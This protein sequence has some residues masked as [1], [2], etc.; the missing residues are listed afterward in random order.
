MGTGQTSTPGQTM[1]SGKTIL[2]NMDE[3]LYTNKINEFVD[4]VSG[5]NVFTGEQVTGGQKVSG[6]SI[7]ELLQDR[8]RNPIVVDEDQTS[9][10][11]R[12]FSSK[13]A[14]DLFYENPS[15][16]AELQLFTVPRPSDYTLS[17]TI[18]NDGDR[19]VKV[20][21]DVTDK[22]VMHFTWKIHNDREDDA[23]DVLNVTYVI[24]NADGTTHTFTRRRNHHQAED[25]SL[26]EFLKPGINDINVEARGNSTGAL[27]SFSFKITVLDLR[28]ECGFNFAGHHAKN[29]ALRVPYSFYRNNTNGTA[30]IYFCIDGVEMPL[31]TVDVLEGGQ[32]TFEDSGKMINPI[33]TEGQHSLQVYAKADYDGL[34]IYSNVL[35]FTFVVDSTEAGAIDKFINVA[36]SLTSGVPPFSTLTLSGVQYYESELKWSYYTYAANTDTKLSV[37]WKLLNGEDDQNPQEFSPIDAQTGYEPDPLA[38][39]PTIYTTTE[40]IY[41]AAYYTAYNGVE[42]EL[43]RIPIYIIQNSALA[44]IYETGSY[45]L[46]MSAYGRTNGSADKAIW[47]DSTDT[48][49]TTFTGIDWNPNNG[50]YDN[51]FRTSGTGHYA[52]VN[53]EPFDNKNGE[54]GFPFTHGKTIEIE[55]ESEKVNSD[56]DILILIGNPQGARIEITPNTATLYANPV[57]DPNTQQRT[58]V[59]VVH[60]NYKSNERIK[61]AFII[62]KEAENVSQRTTDDGLAY[63]VNNGIL[64]RGALASGRSFSTTGAMDLETDPQNPTPIPCK[65]KIGGSNSGVRVYSI[66]VYDK[67]LSYSDAYN[68]FVYDSSD[69]VAI[70]K[71][72]NILSQGEI[73]FDKCR[74][75]IDT[76]VITGDLTD[77]LNQNNDKDTST[78]DV[79][80]ERYCYYDE[81]KDFQIGD[82]IDDPDRPGRQKV[83][84]G[85][86]IRKHGQST[87]NYP[88]A[89][90]KFWMNKSKSGEIPIFEKTGQSKLMLNK[91]R[92]KMKNDSIPSNK[93][94]LQA[95][96]ADSSGVHN[97]GLLRLIQ[98]SWY[99]A[100]IQG[101]SDPYKLRTLPQLFASIKSNEKQNYGLDHVW[102]DYFPGKDFP[103]NIRVAPDSF[104]C[105][106]FYRDLSGSGKYT[107]LGQYVFMDDKK[108]DFVYGERSMYKVQTDPFCLTVTH[109]DEDTKDNRI[110]N[111][112]NVLRIEVLEVNKSYSSYLTDSGFDTFSGGKYGWESQFEMIYPD[113]DDL[114]EDDE[115]DGLSK[116]NSNSHFARAAQPFVD[117]YKWLV[118]TRNNHEKFRAEAEDHLDLYKLAA[119]YI[120]VLRFALVDSLERN[121]QIKTYD[122]VHFHYEPWDMDIALGNKNDGGIAFNPPV[123][124]NTKLNTTTY[125]ISGRAADQNG[126][127][128]SSNWLWDA[129]EAW[130][131][132]MND[133]V[134]K[135]ADALFNTTYLTYDNVSHMF[136]EEYANKWCEIMYNQSGH[137]KYVDSAGGDLQRWLGWLQG[138]RM[139][140]RHWWLSTSMDYYDAKWFCGDYKAHRVYLAANISAD[141]NKSI[142]I[143]PNGSTYMTVTVNYLDDNNNTESEE[144]DTT[145][146]VSKLNPLVYSMEDGASTKAPIHIYGANFMESIDMSD[147]AIGIDALDITGTYS[148]VL[149]APLKVLNIGTPMTENGGVYSTTL[150]P[151]TCGISPVAEGRNAFENLETLNIR[152]HKHLGNVQQF[153]FGINQWI[154]DLNMSQ[155]KNFYAMGSN[156]I[157]FYSSND[158]NNFNEIELPSTVSIINMKNSTWN[159]M[160]FW[161]TTE[162]EN[163]QATITYHQ[164]ALTGGGYAN[165]PSSITEVHFLGS[166]GRTRESLLFVREWIKSIVSTYGEIAL[167]NYTIEMDDV[168]WSPD[169]IGNDADLLTYDELR[170]IAKMNGARTNLRGYVMLQYEGAGTELTSQQLTE[171]RNWFGDSVFTKGSAGLVVDYKHDYIQIN[172]GGDITIENGQMYMAEGGSAILSAT[173]F[174]LA[175]PDQQSMANYEWGLYE[176]GEQELK[177]QIGGVQLLDAS[178]TSDHNYYLVSSESQIGHN[179]DV[180]VRVTAGGNVYS[181]TIHVRAASYPSSISIGT[182]RYGTI[183]PRVSGDIIAIWQNGI[184]CNIFATTNDTYTA[185]IRQVTYEITTENGRT[186]TYSTK[187]GPSWSGERYNIDT[188]I[189]I[190]EN[191]NTLGINN[192]PCIRVN[193]PDGVP[194]DESIYE[195]NL[196]I[197]VEFNSD[198]EVSTTA[199][200]LVL[201]D[202][203]PIVSAL[204]EYMYAAIADRWLVQYG[205]TLQAS[206]L[207][208]TDL[209]N[210]TGTLT[211]STSLQNLVTAKGTTSLLKY[212]P[213]VT[214]L[215]FDGNSNLQSTNNSI[216]DDN[217]NQFIFTNMPNLETLSIQNCTGLTADIDLSS[218]SHITQVD[219]SGTFVNILVPE[220]AILTKYEVGTPTEISLI[221]PTVLT[222]AGVKVDNCS[223]LN[224]LDITNIPNNNSFSMFEKIMKTFIAGG[225]ILTGMSTMDRSPGY[226]Q[227]D[228]ENKYITS[229]IQVNGGDSIHVDVTND[230]DVVQFN[231]NKEY[232]TYSHIFISTYPNGRDITLNNNTR[233]IIAGNIY[234]A[235]PA[236]ITIT[237]NADFSVLFNY[238]IPT[239]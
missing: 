221:N 88:I 86:Q 230:C 152:G 93:F 233:Y 206:R 57:V 174:H 61:L 70:V 44:N 20:G 30:K 3:Q 130:P 11:Y 182:S 45:E 24:T 128:I 198:K 12:F 118:S 196:T 167:S 166:T 189:N 35:Y 153:T 225:S 96:Y 29:E 175:E 21:D 48:I 14:Q 137:F 90:M 54:S 13:T 85:C 140:H 129:L 168:F 178:Q 158:G 47:K 147:I 190:Q 143:T 71:R 51:S 126:D 121:A 106:V 115:K 235:R 165:I 7:R 5:E 134:P 78:T 117:W 192:T 231:S 107:F 65:I 23:S 66:R 92:Y 26:Y 62:N 27:R 104:P 179:Y 67:S 34:T 59:E 133:I 97:G 194:N 195:Y 200:I 95:N 76:I 187:I 156:L 63:I 138:A 124:R 220:N 36:A 148:D 83:V 201:N 103:Y 102:A 232:I 110:W 18:S 150:S 114:E 77:I 132:W 84:N 211:F 237:N 8:L 204:Q 28:I 184:G 160:T 38:Y 31:E 239:V 203:T 58:Q 141:P 122:G 208:R 172:V 4:W 205:E 197:T 6:G 207:Y 116:G 181:A 151:S 112:G 215:V 119:Y 228:N 213:N 210:I 173:E 131:R 56:S 41:L 19:F 94:V 2:I 105:A 155:L 218:C 171:I 40:Q 91:N 149:G 60:T 238:I 161:D 170:L 100:R 212:I 113:P 89:S 191:T 32:L 136:D 37:T 33:L 199:R 64:E 216:I 10:L 135:V 154:R 120:F 109:K 43:V 101:V 145:R 52:V 82:V 217:H 55:F 127:I 81:T 164:E 80:L 177:Y 16:N 25:Y 108:S 234:A 72:N 49:T 202:S 163:D 185:T 214:G 226:Q 17:L 142:R 144:V 229:F 74:D 73:S 157:N 159:S 99:N 123:D 9:N 39:T 223:S 186:A 125:A 227:V 50:W 15:D 209:L 46:K 79:M 219:A 146:E 162:G 183:E 87:L 193:C 53:F 176:P 169:V 188:R 180:E 222:V 69:K 1:L 98:D 224:S 111:N 139:S 68:N 236:S 75:M 42:T 22:T